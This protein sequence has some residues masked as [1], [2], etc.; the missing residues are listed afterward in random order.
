MESSIRHN[1]ANVRYGHR[2]CNVAMSDHSLDETLDFMEYIVRANE[3][4]A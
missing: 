3:R 2:W 1:A 4:I